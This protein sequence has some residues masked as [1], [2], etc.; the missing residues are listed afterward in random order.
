[1]KTEFHIK[2]YVYEEDEECS[3][4]QFLTS[5]TQCWVAQIIL[6]IN[7]LR[8]VNSL[9]ATTHLLFELGSQNLVPVIPYLPSMCCH[10]QI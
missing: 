3:H 1:M 9:E 4:K 10:F 8:G 7:T 5:K 2:Y 6:Y